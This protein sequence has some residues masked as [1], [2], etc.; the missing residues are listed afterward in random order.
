M[1]SPIISVITVGMNHLKYIKELYHSLYADESCPK[2]A[3]EAIYVDNCS[4]DG[5]VEFLK[6]NYPLLT[7][8]KSA[9]SSTKHSSVSRLL[10]FIKQMYPPH[11][12]AFEFFYPVVFICYCPANRI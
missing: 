4:T 1:N 12:V 10:C 3:F 8:V 9:A 5:S 11:K 6:K 2:T 7:S